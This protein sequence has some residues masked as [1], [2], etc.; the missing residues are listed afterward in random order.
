MSVVEEQLKKLKMIYGVAPLYRLRYR[1]DYA[2]RPSVVGGWDRPHDDPKD[3]VW[4]KTKTGLVRVAIEGERRFYWTTHTLLE[5][6][7]H[8]FASLRWVNLLSLGGWSA[9]D[10][11]ASG[12]I[13]GLTIL[14]GSKAAT[15]FIDGSGDVRD[16]TDYE[17][18]FKLKE[19]NI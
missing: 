18:K 9:G 3:Q 11:T 16:L 10:F 8:D 14:T 4:S 19:H 12:S 15:V 13:A 6:D 7:G 17:K 1:L 5:V 2:G